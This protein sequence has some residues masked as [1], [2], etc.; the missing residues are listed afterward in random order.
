MTEK[1][2]AETNVAAGKSAKAKAKGSDDRVAGIGLFAM[3]FYALFVKKVIYTK[4]RFILYTIM[5]INNIHTWL[6]CAH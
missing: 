2:Q 6:K 4:R 5:V 1:N 3:Q